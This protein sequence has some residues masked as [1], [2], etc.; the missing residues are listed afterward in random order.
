M[1]RNRT[2]I[3]KYYYVGDRKVQVLHTRLKTKC[4][5]L[6]YDLFLKNIVESPLCK[7]GSTENAQHYFFHCPRYTDIRRNLINSL[8]QLCTISFDILMYGNNS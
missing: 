6:N 3:P 5:S 8:S 7:C 4:S 2:T 1:N